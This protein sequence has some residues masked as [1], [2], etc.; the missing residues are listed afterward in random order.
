MNPVTT[1]SKLSIALILL[2]G[3]SHT[4]SAQESADATGIA[5]AT[6]ISPDALATARSPNSACSNA[7]SESKLRQREIALLGP[8]HAAKHAEARAHKCRIA[9]GLEKLQ[10]A[11]PETLAVFAAKPASAVGRWSAPFNIPVVGVTAVMLNTGKV[12]FWS[13]NP[14]DYQNPDAS[15]TGVAYIWDPVTRTGHSITPPENIWCG[16]QTLLSDGRVYTAGGNL[17]YP[18]PNAPPGQTGWEGSFTD[19]TF[20]PN[21]ETWT[22]QPDMSVGRWYPTVTQLS[23]NR[24]VITSGYDQTGTTDSSGETISLTQIVEAFT[25]SP[26]I[27]GVGTIKAV[28]M[29][30]PSGVY[31]YQ[32][33]IRTG[34]MLQAGPDAGNTYTLAPSNWNWSPVPNMLS[35]HYGYG[36]GVIYTDTSVSPVSQVV[37]IAGGVDA[38]T[39]LSNN[40]YLDTFNMNAGWRTFPQWQQTR[41]NVNTVMLPDGKLFTVAGNQALSS[42]DSPLFEAEMYSKPANDPTGTWKVMSPNTLQA[43]YHSTAILLPDA[44]VLL[45]QDDEDPSQAQNHQ[46]QVYSPPYLFTGTTRPVIKSAPSATTRGQTIAVT[47]NATNIV[48]ATLVAP[49]ATTHANDM[50]QRVIKVKTTVS[51]KTV[52]VTVPT[53]AALVPP[54]FYMLFLIDDSGV[55]SKAS[56]IRIT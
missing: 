15:N 19:Y 50:H 22:K 38:N 36:S 33:L 2:F 52:H 53:S 31:P 30:D 6:T 49:G 25:P 9:L 51:A 35:S 23:D 44:T 14:P 4:I 5:V 39:T 24:V 20:D 48:S 45:S 34:N 8:D 12:L 37:M 18:D 17:R 46:A 16:G 21:T 40:E 10:G 26:S 11:R 54:G 7:A 28:S 27:N 1:K 42:Y 32:Y 43:A 47:T 13:Y 56:F 3:A 29:H 55:P 41:H